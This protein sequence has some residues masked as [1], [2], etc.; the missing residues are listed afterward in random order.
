MPLFGGKKDKR[1]EAEPSKPL[2]VLDD[3]KNRVELWPNKLTIRR[4]GLMNAMTVGLVGEKDIYLNTIVGIQVKKPGMTV[5]YIQFMA[6]GSQDNKS[7]VTGAVQDE[8]TVVFNGKKNYEIAQ[9]MKA[10]IEELRHEPV[11]AVAPP[12]SAADE[13]V[14][15]AS[16]RD[17]GILTSEEFEEQKKLLLGAKK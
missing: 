16:L 9:V 17:Q 7:G 11:A 2:M 4:H 8:N 13:L 6:H 3:K 14:K 15:F 12:T 5:G 1:D 10:K